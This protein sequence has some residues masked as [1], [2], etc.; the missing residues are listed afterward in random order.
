MHKEKIMK[1][2]S[3]IIFECCKQMKKEVPSLTN[4]MRELL[5]ESIWGYYKGVFENCIFYKSIYYDDDRKQKKIEEIKAKT[6]SLDNDG[7]FAEIAQVWYLFKYEFCDDM[8]I[9]MKLTYII[10]EML[11]KFMEHRLKKTLKTEEISVQLVFSELEKLKGKEKNFI[12]KTQDYY[13]YLIFTEMIL[14]VFLD[15]L[16]IRF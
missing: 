9:K 8:Y 7:I 1:T 2:I 12:E 6:V 16:I 5:E 10:N 14:T 13:F 11:C 15:Y 4:E 3:K